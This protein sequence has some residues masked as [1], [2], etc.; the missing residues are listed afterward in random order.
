[1]AA[2][3]T[4]YGSHYAFDHT[5]GHLAVAYI[6]TPLIKVDVPISRASENII[7]D[8]FGSRWI[9]VLYLLQRKD[10]VQGVILLR[11]F[12]HCCR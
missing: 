12:Y 11:S 3:Y 4:G 9:P 2:I 7:L 1:M 6:S 8:T 10:I 5:P